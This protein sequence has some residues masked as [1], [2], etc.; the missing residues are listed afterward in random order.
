MLGFLGLLIHLTPVETAELYAIK[1]EQTSP[2]LFAMISFMGLSILLIGFYV[3]A[4]NT[5]LAHPRAIASTLL[6]NALFVTKFAFG[7]ADSLGLAR[8][9]PLTWSVVNVGLAVTALAR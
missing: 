9:G 4:L 2:L 3:G 5:G 6:V 7:D 8:T 1:P